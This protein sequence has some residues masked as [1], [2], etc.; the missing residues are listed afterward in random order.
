MR[1]GSDTVAKNNTIATA[2]SANRRLSARC[3][4]ACAC[5]TEQFRD[6]LALTHV[7]TILS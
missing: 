4:Y 7:L 6:M 2:W 1:K 5:V 3:N